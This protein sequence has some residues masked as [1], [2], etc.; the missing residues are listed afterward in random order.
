M[1]DLQAVLFGDFFILDYEKKIIR[2]IL[3]LPL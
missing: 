1:F 2:A 3:I